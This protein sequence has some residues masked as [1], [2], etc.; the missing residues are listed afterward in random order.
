M[1]KATAE[2]TKRSKGRSKSVEQTVRV[3]LRKALPILVR[4]MSDMLEKRPPRMTNRAKRE[5]QCQIDQYIRKSVP[6]INELE[7]L[8]GDPLKTPRLMRS[9]NC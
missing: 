1:P 4:E 5:M 3:G 2:T 8:E 7:R 6:L 9:S